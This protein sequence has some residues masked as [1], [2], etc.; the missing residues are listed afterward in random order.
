MRAVIVGAAGRMGLAL[1]QLA[2]QRRTVESE[3]RCGLR[4]IAAGVLQHDAKQRFFY[5]A[6]HEIVQWRGVVT[7]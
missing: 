3:D 1:A 5:F 4:L 7:V 6:Q 2:P